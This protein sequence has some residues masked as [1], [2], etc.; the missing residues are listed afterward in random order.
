ML[1]T[2]LIVRVTLPTVPAWHGRSS[3][4]S[5]LPETWRSL[6]GFKC[7]IIRMDVAIALTPS[8]SAE[9]DDGGQPL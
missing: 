8:D 9:N 7:G 2:C 4:Q 6:A 3:R 1:I 5:S